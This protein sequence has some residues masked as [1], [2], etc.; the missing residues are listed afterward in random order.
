MEKI[1]L[2]AKTSVKCN[3]IRVGRGT[4]LW[5]IRFRQTQG[6]SSEKPGASPK[7][8]PFEGWGAVS[9]SEEEGRS[10]GSKPKSH[11]FSC[12]F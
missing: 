4:L 1:C 2:G 12:S 9:D 10:R 11:P 5:F 8:A 3:S 7:D 6:S